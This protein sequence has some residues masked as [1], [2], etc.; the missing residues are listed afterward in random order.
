MDFHESPVFLVFEQGPC[1]VFM[2][3]KQGEAA[4]V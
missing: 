3:L 2:S 1:S 4:A